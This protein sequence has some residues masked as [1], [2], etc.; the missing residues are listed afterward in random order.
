[1]GNSLHFGVTRRL[2]APSH[3]VWRVLADFGTEHRRT[4]SLSHCERD[5]AEVSVG[6]ARICTL[7][8]PL[9]GRTEVRE[10]L[11]E[12]EPGRVLAYV[13]D[14]SAG[15]FASASSRWSTSPS[16]ENT[17]A[18]TVE[19]RFEPKKRL[20]RVLVWPLA[21][22]MLRRLTRRIIGELEEYVTAATAARSG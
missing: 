16:S 12:F 11:T 6:T 9:M 20:G 15:P 17:T 2:H 8:K 4:K 1:M 7:P 21:K 3:E 22:P 10:T 13:L 5:T 14:G 19:G 18:V